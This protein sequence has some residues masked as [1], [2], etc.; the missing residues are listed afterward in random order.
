MKLQALLLGA[1][2]LLGAGSL[3]ATALDL[4]GRMQLRQQRSLPAVQR[5]G[6]MRAAKLP[7]NGGITLGMAV[8]DDDRAVELLETK[9]A[10]VLRRRGN[11]V[12]VSMPTDSV[13]SLAATHGVRRM[14][15]ARRLNPQL[16]KAR[17]ASKA[18]LLHSG[19]DLPRAY[20]GKGVVTGI[21]DA[22]M[23][24]NHVNFLDAD[25]NNRVQYLGHLRVNSSGSSVLETRYGIMNELQVPIFKTDD[26]A[27]YH[28]TH[29]MGIM[30]GGYK[31]QATVA[32][33]DRA[34]ATSTL[35]AMPNPYYGVATESDIAASCG[36]LM[37]MLIATGVDDICE[38]NFRKAQ[39]DGK[40]MQRMA[41]NLSLGSNVGPHDGSDVIHQFLDLIA[42]QDG[43]I[44]CV[45]AGNEG[46]LPIALHGTIGQDKP[47]LKTF[48]RPFVYS[49]VRYGNLA[50]Y[51]ADSTTFNLRAVVYN[52]SRGRVAFDIPVS[53]ST[54]GQPTYFISGE[55][56]RMSNDDQVSA[57]LARA[58]DG[59][60][61]AGS[62]YDTN[63]GRYYAMIDYYCVDAAT[64]QD[65]NY[66]LGFIVTPKY[67]DQPLRIDAY[68]DGAFCAFDA[69]GQQGWDE[70]M[71]DGTISDMACGR[72]VIAVGSYNTRQDWGS[73][74]GYL[75]GYNGAFPEQE[76][77][78]FSSW[79]TLADGRQL[80]HV[81]APGAAIISSINSYMVSDPKNEIGLNALQ[82][83]AIGADGRKYH[84]MQTTGT[85]MASPYV[86]GSIAC[87]LEAD[88]TL[89]LD[90]VRDIIATTAIRDQQVLD[91][92]PVKWG[93]GKFDAHAGLVEVLR[94]ASAAVGNVSA[95]LDQRLVA[96]ADGSVYTF[97]LAG[98]QH[99]QLQLFDL[100]GKLVAAAQ[101]LGDSVSADLGHL[102]A[103]VYVAR[104]NGQ[105][106]VKI[107]R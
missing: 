17:A 18:D 22:G 72:S 6:A 83:E 16:D 32:V 7:A 63:T 85:S 102:P 100:G 10:T 21:V 40:P 89:T 69:Y 9:G 46:D 27:Q 60:V 19:T 101:T 26:A 39:R 29:T 24:P 53:A 12:M 61:G 47:E 64:N 107:T 58:F 35:T 103:G 13:E 93:A 48:I 52:K 37:D 43:A 62:M 50:I 74:D 86:A 81:C 105:H 95:D 82:A 25:G 38:F 66:L 94:R 71:Y 36:D 33:G 84:W 59:Y 44:I 56:F 15:L 65:G 34:T 80:P 97:M 51:S 14:Q 23:D 28:G 3:Q 73:L 104:V 98:E 57:T 49:N 96:S 76:V 70:G 31:G 75:Y 45:S 79:G 2:L 78:S 30:A 91:G 67:P 68:G 20:T 99:M 8:V 92:N 88:P 11:I 77:T 106:S 5:S 87:W 42:Q 1:T 90:A 41:I 55:D 4:H 54:D